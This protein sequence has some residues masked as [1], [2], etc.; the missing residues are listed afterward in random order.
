MLRRRC[1]FANRFHVSHDSTSISSRYVVHFRTLSSQTK[2]SKDDEYI[3]SEEASENTK[4]QHD[5]IIRLTPRQKIREWTRTYHQIGSSQWIKNHFGI[6]FWALHIKYIQSRYLQR[7]WATRILRR[8]GLG[9]IWN[10]K[11]ITYPTQ[12]KLD[13]DKEEEEEEDRDVLSSLQQEADAFD[14]DDLNYLFYHRAPNGYVTSKD[15]HLLQLENK[16]QT[17]DEKTITDSLQFWFDTFSARMY[18]DAFDLKDGNVIFSMVKAKEHA[19]RQDAKVNA[20]RDEESNLLKPSDATKSVNPYKM[21]PEENPQS[22]F[23]QYGSQFL[24]DYVDFKPPKSKAMIDGNSEDT[25]LLGDGEQTQVTEGDK[26]DYKETQGYKLNRRFAWFRA[27][28]NGQSLERNI[29]EIEAMEFPDKSDANYKEIERIMGERE[30]MDLRRNDVS[31]WHQ[32]KQLMPTRRE[33][34]IILKLKQ[35]SFWKGLSMLFDDYKFVFSGGGGEVL[36]RGYPP[37]MSLQEFNCAD[38]FECSQGRFGAMHSLFSDW[39][40][41]I[42]NKREACDRSYGSAVIV[43]DRLIF[44]GFLIHSCVEMAHRTRVKA[45]SAREFVGFVNLVSHEFEPEWDLGAYYSIGLKLRSDGRPYLLG[46]ECLCR[47]RFIVFNGIISI[48]PTPDGD[49]DYYEIPLHH[50]RPYDNGEFIAGFNWMHVRYVRSIA[51]QAIGCTGAFNLEVQWIRAMAFEARF[52]VEDEDVTFIQDIDALGIYKEDLLKFHIIQHQ[53]FIDDFA[54]PFR[55]EDNGV[56]DDNVYLGTPRA[57]RQ[58]FGNI[59]APDLLRYVDVIDD[60]PC[61]EETQRYLDYYLDDDD[62]YMAQNY[63][64]QKLIGDSKAIQQIFRHDSWSISQATNNLLFNQLKTQSKH[65]QY[66]V[67]GVYH[68]ENIHRYKPPDAAT[69]TPFLFKDIKQ[70]SNNPITVLTQRRRELLRQS[71]PQ[72]LRERVVGKWPHL[73]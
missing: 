17:D 37:Q 3:K 38:Q 67:S 52:D 30:E 10:L 36:R 40:V 18:H 54:D 19:L 43:D 25:V 62:M 1:D 69:K 66:L 21:I 8:E 5:E 15:E 9:E 55:F 26:D 58:H 16:Q 20:I 56:F 53:Y 2:I 48:A 22:E 7:M 29:R 23:I 49:W 57:Q 39:F 71:V 50:F 63:L 27:K 42:D 6:P 12:I 11:S 34:G 28:M 72:H 44:C 60:I 47:N 64:N 73:V 32:L 14:T 65:N 41:A 13:K 24:S 61:S 31:G 46:L 45:P 59:I 70:T 68:N 51:I 33:I 4:Y 35:L